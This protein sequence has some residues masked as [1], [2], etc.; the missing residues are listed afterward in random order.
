MTTF[1]KFSNILFKACMVFAGI[2]FS[3]NWVDLMNSF[4]HKFIY[5]VTLMNILYTS[6]GMPFRD[7]LC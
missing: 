4:I 2:G 5:K 3:T 1:E 7:E 6:M